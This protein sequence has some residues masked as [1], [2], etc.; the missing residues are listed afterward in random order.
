M[1]LKSTD[2]FI[3]TSLKAELDVARKQVETL[4]LEVAQQKEQLLRALMT[5]D[6]LREQLE[7]LGPAA[8]PAPPP[9]AVDESASA[10][11]K[12]AQAEFVRKTNEAIE[13]LRERVKLQKEVSPL[14]SAALPRRRTELAGDDDGFLGG[15]L[16]VVRRAGE[17]GD[18]WALVGEDGL[19]EDHHHGPVS[20]SAARRGP[21]VRVPPPPPDAML[22]RETTAAPTGSGNRKKSS[23]RDRVSMLFSSSRIL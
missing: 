17:G 13:K 21:L 3:S 10:A 18:A 12:A 2:E 22:A 15:A 5:K 20:S 4:E 14:R 7:K 6:E 9:P 11:E 1:A 19:A 16:A 8:A 23:V